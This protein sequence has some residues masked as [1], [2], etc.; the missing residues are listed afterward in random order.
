M[1]ELVPIVL[2]KAGMNMVEATIIDWHK[3]VGEQVDAG[4]PL[5][6]IETDKVEMEIEAPVAGTLT[7]ILVAAGEDAP[8]GAELGLIATEA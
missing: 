1:G 3:E 4:E 6:D 8:V 2:L 7:A 5:V